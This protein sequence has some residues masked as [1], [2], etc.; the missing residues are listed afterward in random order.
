M[1]VILVN[2]SAEATAGAPPED[3]I[4]DGRPEWSTTRDWLSSDGTMAAGTWTSTKGL[5]R[6]EI[7]RWEYMQILKGRCILTDVAGVRTAIGAGDSVVLE[8]GFRGT[9]QVLEPMTKKYF[10]RYR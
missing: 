3:R 6:V 7:D 4:I 10:A 1:P 8:P 5:W 9:W 2:G